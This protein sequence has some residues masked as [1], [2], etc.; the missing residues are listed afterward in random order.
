MYRSSCAALAVVWCLAIAFIF[1]HHGFLCPIGWLVLF[2]SS[3]SSHL[4]CRSHLE[5]SGWTALHLANAIVDL[6]HCHSCQI[7]ISYS[8][9]QQKIYT[10]LIIIIFMTFFF[11]TKPAQIIH[12]IFHIFYFFFLFSKMTHII[13]IIRIGFSFCL[14]CSFFSSFMFLFSKRYCMCSKRQQ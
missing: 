5:L 12:T 3:H 7:A 11:N 9:S 4:P 10:V 13:H 1:V 14:P 2:L 6:F 8:T